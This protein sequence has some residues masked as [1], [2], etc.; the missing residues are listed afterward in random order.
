MPVRVK[1]CGMTSA[2]DAH[3]A[4]AAGAEA[5]GFVFVPGTPRAMTPE[6]VRPIIAELPG[7]IAKVGLFVN[8]SAAEIA[9]VIDRTG[10][11]TIQLHGEETPALAALFTGRV[12]VWK[13]F[14]VRDAAALEPV[15][16]YFGVCDAVLLDAYV[17]GAHGGT[18][19][20]FDWT[21]AEEIRGWP[22]PVIIAGGLRPDN[23]VAAIRKFAPWAVDVSS[24]V[25][26]APGIK[27]AFKV[28]Q[29]VHLAHSAAMSP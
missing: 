12:T 25:E 29:F 26:A 9:D 3:V 11:D 6:R 8:S 18:G 5:V 21:L 17:A 27:D 1:I 13:A 16:D 2:A 23:V 15:P 22:K 28:R 24:G 14:R 20:Q 10:L 19:A 7:R 4:V